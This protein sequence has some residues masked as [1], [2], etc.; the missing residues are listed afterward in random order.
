MWVLMDSAHTGPP[1]N[2]PPDCWQRAV[3]DG[4][5]FQLFKRSQLTGCHFCG[6]CVC[7]RADLCATTVN[8]YAGLCRLEAKKLWPCLLLGRFI[9]L[10]CQSEMLRKALPPSR[11]LLRLGWRA[12][13]KKTKRRKQ[14]FAA[15]KCKQTKIKS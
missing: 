8:N 7:G 11:S 1:T 2:A 6:L 15:L 14:T 9:S 13:H 12:E 10:S 3:A 5:D 4:T